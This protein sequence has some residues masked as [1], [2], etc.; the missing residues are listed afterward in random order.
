MSLTFARLF[1]RLPGL[2]A[3]VVA[4]AVAAVRL[5]GGVGLALAL[6]SAASAAVGAV[7]V[8]DTLTVIQRPLL[9]IPA[10]VAPGGILAIQ[11]EAAPA[12]SGWTAELRRG[13]IRLPLEIT[14]SAY[15]SST[16]WW[17]ITA[18]A[19]EPEVYDLYDLAVGA[20]GGIADTT[21]N[22]VR[23]IPEIKDD[24]YF[25]HITDTHL[26]T[27]LYYYEQG[28]DTDSSGIVDLRE[29][30]GDVNLIN[31]EFV[32]LT[33]DLIHEG[34][35]EDFL[36]KRYFSR[37]Q[38]LLTEFQ[39]PVYLTAGNHDI[40][41]W[42]ATPPPDGT[43]RR[44]WW[45]FFGWKR[46]DDPPAGAPARTQDF[47]FDYGPVHYV[48]LEAYNNY[49]YWRPEIYGGDSFTQAQLAWLEDDLEAA[50]ASSAKVLFYHSDFLRQV[51]LATLGADMSLAGHTHSNREDFSHP[52]SIVTGSATGRRA[53]R[54]VRVTGGVLQPAAALSAGSSGDNLRVD[55]APAN[56]GTNY[57]VTATVTN[58]LSQRFEH[59][60]VRFVMPNEPGTPG[61]V[62]GALLQI[63]ASGPQAVWYVA[64]DVPASSSLAV[65]VTLDTTD[66]EAPEVTVV[67][68]NGQESWEVGSTYDVA[69]TATDNFGV[70]TVAI[71]LSR[72][73]GAVYGDTL[74]VG[75]ANDGLYSW[76]VTPDATAAA[77]VMVVAADR[78][79]NQGADA[80]D[81]EFEIK[82]Q[83]AGIPARVVI[84]G[85]SPNPFGGR[86]EIRFGLPRPG[87]VEADLYDVA[88]HLVTSVMRSEYDEGFHSFDWDDHGKVSAGIYFLRLRLGS[89]TAT[90]KLVIPR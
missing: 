54:L 70:V 49:D 11:C 87:V 56:D 26:P 57:G 7:P 43:A 67:A 19:P 77:R 38:R 30:I 35:L 63:D 9:N 37:G 22:A 12:T 4:G 14:G 21:R 62:G 60:L 39:V 36:E 34:E 79:G 42:D 90:S 2:R 53:Y 50:S 58:N 55:F 5:A 80:S 10:I 64:A 41:G 75:E 32:L 78:G 31:P 76:T 72:D 59:S 13:E 25:V 65:T 48:G 45:R 28:S 61:V 46:L 27:S 23:V 20:S 6:G 82:E 69:W 17:E 47:S 15:N 73:G 51:N 85:A 29:I 24:Y 86:T 52:Y 89:E 74:A 71:L 1:A 40:G 44:T 88:G 84:T 83:T 68:P 16:L 3:G 66:L 8:G 81:G 33:G 18:L